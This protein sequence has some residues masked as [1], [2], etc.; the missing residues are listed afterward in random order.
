MDLYFA[1]FGSFLLGMGMMGCIWV[2]EIKIIKKDDNI[3][4]LHHWTGRGESVVGE[5]KK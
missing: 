3:N 4:R 5:D 1:C 2:S